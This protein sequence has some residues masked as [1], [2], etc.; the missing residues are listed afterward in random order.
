MKNIKDQIEEIK[1]DGYELDFGTVFE[2]AFEN[3]KKIALY[4]GLMLLVFTILFGSLL[5]G[6][7]ISIFGV[8]TVTEALKPE[9][10]KPETFSEKFLLIYTATVILI[11]CLLSPFQAGFF[12]MA[13]CGEKGEE[14]HV[15]TIFGYYK[16]PY[17]MN[18]VA[19]TF[20]IT[21]MSSGLSILLDFTGIKTIGLLASLTISFI[22]FLTIP[23]IVFGKLN[24]V[25]A[26]KSSMIIVLKKPSLLLRLL[27]VA[28]IAVFI[29]FFAFC[30][31]LF[32]TLPFLYSMKYSIYNFIIGIDSTN[33]SKI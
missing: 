27:I 32:F 20:I 28:I 5:F 24:A 17:F 11:T 19:S 33:K 22:T 23:L 2:H 29:G 15:S 16:S 21:L 1:R 10:L 3:Y 6:I 9:N 12:K 8:E 18:I 26:I 14:F 13:D 7:A 30:I 31:G 25:E 4:A